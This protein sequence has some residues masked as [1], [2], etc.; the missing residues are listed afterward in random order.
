MKSLLPILNVLLCASSLAFGYEEKG[1][2][3]RRKKRTASL[4]A[5][6]KGQCHQRVRIHEKYPY[7]A[8]TPATWFHSRISNRII[9][10]G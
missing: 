9:G 6:P 5:Q 7:Y 4:M 3:P 10:I 8:N 2:S 1:L